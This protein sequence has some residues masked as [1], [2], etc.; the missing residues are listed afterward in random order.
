M[1]EWERG[2]WDIARKLCPNF[3]WDYQ[4]EH[5]DDSDHDPM[6][7]C[8]LCN[9]PMHFYRM[10]GNVAQYVCNG[11]HCANNPNSDWKTK[12]TRESVIAVGNEALLWNPPETLI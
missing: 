11:E 1:K 9:G 5:P 10:K 2:A 12:F 8:R 6:Y 4:G 7:R 3:K